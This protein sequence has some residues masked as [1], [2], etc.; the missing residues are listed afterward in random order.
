MAK[1]APRL[2]V[3]TSEYDEE[4]YTAEDAARDEK[5][6]AYHMREKTHVTGPTKRLINYMGRPGAK[7]QKTGDVNLP[8]EKKKKQGPGSRRMRD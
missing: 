4:P 1:K 6:E 5:S 2:R 3:E 8:V 7:M